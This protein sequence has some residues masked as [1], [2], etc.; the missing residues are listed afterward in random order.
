MRGGGAVT[1]SSAAAAHVAH[2]LVDPLAVAS[3]ADGEA[4]LELLLLQ[5]RGD[6]GV[7]ALRPLAA[8][9]GDSTAATDVVAVAEQLQVGVLSACLPACP[10]VWLTGWPIGWLVGWLTVCLQHAWLTSHMALA[11]HPVLRMSALL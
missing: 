7:A 1:S 10:A 4:L 3:V 8:P 5:R 9:L 2:L 11:A 6:G